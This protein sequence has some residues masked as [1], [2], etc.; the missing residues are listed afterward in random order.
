MNNKDIEKI[1]ELLSQEYSIFSETDHD[2]I[3]LGLSE[4]PFKNLVSVVLSTVTHTKR[5][6]K[7]CV[8]LF[9]KA[10]TPEEILALSDEELKTL[11]QP[12]A[13]Y[14]RKAKQL[15]IM[16]QQ[17]IDRHNGQVPQHL[18][19]LLA[20]TGVGEKCTNLIMNFNFGGNQIAVDTHIQRLMKRLGWV[21]HNHRAK[22]FKIINEIT[23]DFYKKHAHEWLIQH[24]QK[25]CTARNPQCGKCLIKDY[26]LF[27]SS[28]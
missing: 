25:V 3:K 9:A 8:P 2:W 5:V 24:G 7:A 10:S 11:I 13:H 20:L 26:C 18:N 12:V 14:N 1:Y 15:K 6:I 23:P 17:L 22:S 27:I 16:C 21:N 4:T 28:H 19:D